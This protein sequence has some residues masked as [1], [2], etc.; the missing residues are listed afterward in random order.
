MENKMIDLESVTNYK[1]VTNCDVK[2]LL[3]SNKNEWSAIIPYGSNGNILSEV[4][5]SGDPVYNIQKAYNTVISYG[6]NL[7]PFLWNAVDDNTE[8]DID[9][10]R[11]KKLKDSIINQGKHPGKMVITEDLHLEKEWHEEAKKQ[12]LRTLPKFIKHLMDDYAHSYGT[13]VKAMACAVYATIHVCNNMPSGSITG[14]QASCLVWQI[15]DEMGMFKSESGSR[16]LTFDDMLYPQNS[17]RFSCIDKDTW[18]KLQELAKSKLEEDGA[19]HPDVRKHL[20]SIVNGTVPFGWKVV[21]K[22]W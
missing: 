1:V 9:L 21:D 3:L 20:Q 17:N 2:I 5:N 18:D 14:F 22:V 12:T 8:L 16:I 11:L 15:I 7:R 13:I 19:M 4:T 10:K 6:I